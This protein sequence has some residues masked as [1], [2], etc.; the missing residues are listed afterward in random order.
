[1]SWRY[2]VRCDMNSTSPR[3]VWYKHSQLHTPPFHEQIT[4][5]LVLQSRA[6]KPI[7]SWADHHNAL[8]IMPD[9]SLYPLLTTMRTKKNQWKYKGKSSSGVLLRLE[10]MTTED[11]H[12]ATRKTRPIIDAKMGDKLGVIHSQKETSEEQENLLLF[13]DSIT[14]SPP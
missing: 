3:L 10:D 8:N 6:M 11:C 4:A 14:S 1:M 13:Q 2:L 5:R 7:R 12:L 9:P